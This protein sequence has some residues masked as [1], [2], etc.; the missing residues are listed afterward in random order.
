MTSLIKNFSKHNARLDNSVVK[1]VVV[2]R[3]ESIE[4]DHL[5]SN[6]GSVTYYGCDPGQIS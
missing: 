5:C 4:A 6:L 2:E 1:W 3:L